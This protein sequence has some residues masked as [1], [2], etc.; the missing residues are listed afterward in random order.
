MMAEKAGKEVCL[1]VLGEKE[2]SFLMSLHSLDL[3]A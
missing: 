3:K 1:T 2:T